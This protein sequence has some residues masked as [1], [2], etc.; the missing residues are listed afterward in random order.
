MATEAKLTEASESDKRRW[1]MM[2]RRFVARGTTIFDE[3]SFNS[4]LAIESLRVRRSGLRFALMLLSVREQNGSSAEI[5]YRAFRVVVERM[6]Q[7][8][9]I[10]WSEEGK[11]LGVIFT[12]LPAEQLAV[13][14]TL[15]SAVKSNLQ[16]SLGREM[17]RAITAS[18]Q[19]FPESSNGNDPIITAD[20]QPAFGIELQLLREKPGFADS[21]APLYQSLLKSFQSLN[22]GRTR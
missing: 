17:A 16:V 9:V 7:T 5:L 2:G 14:Q 20:L 22:F 18:V 6:R 12:Q 19:V 3:N 21:W 8:D 11:T 13:N 15:Y 1:A 4:L 10:G